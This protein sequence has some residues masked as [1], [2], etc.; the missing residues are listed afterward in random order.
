[1][2]TRTA[3]GAGDPSSAPWPP[4]GPHGFPQPTPRPYPALRRL[5]APGLRVRSGATC[6]WTP[7]PV[8]ATPALPL[9]L[10]PQPRPARG[11]EQSL[12][13][14]TRQGRTASFHAAPPLH[15]LSQDQN[16]LGGAR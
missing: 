13:A 12:P 2:I 6:G 16:A 3:G 10:D 7:R 9:E 14:H 11:A 8:L 15:R 4:T 5:R 1:M